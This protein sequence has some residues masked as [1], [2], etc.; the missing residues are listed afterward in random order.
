MLRRLFVLLALK[1]LINGCVYAEESIIEVIPLFNR[2]ASEIQPLLNPLLG[3][4]DRVIADGTNLLVR[5]SPQRLAEIKSFIKKLDIRLNNL[6]ITVLQSRQATADELNAS[7][8]AR[9][10]FPANDWS[11]STGKITGYYYQ[12][13]DR[14]AHDNLQTIRALEGNP[15]YI[16]TGNTVPIQNYQ[17]YNSG[18]GYSGFSSTTEFIDAT[19]G[20]SVTP[21]LSG[22][23]VILEVSPWSDTFNTHGQIQTQQAESTLKVNLGEWIELGSVDESTQSGGNRTLSRSWQTN[24]NRLH[25]LIKVDRAD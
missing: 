11:K 2:P 12:T 13:E 19:T 15:A 8:S 23:Q 14:Y 21:R 5:T 4:S 16:K 1:M 17:T 3:D 7:A 6:V 18:Y 24:E 10:Q 20:F 25:I 9:L 22:Q